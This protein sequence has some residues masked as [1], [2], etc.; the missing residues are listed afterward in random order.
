MNE[1]LDII[2][3]W[4]ALIALLISVGSAIYAFVTARSKANSERLDA[5]DKRLGTHADRLQKL[6]S[7]VSHL[8][9]KDQVNGLQVTIAEVKGLVGVLNE[10]VDGV[11]AIVTRID[12]FLLEMGR[13]K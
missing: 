11:G 7:E 12:K 8:P 9:N 6:E 4:L 1:A 10:R 5:I 2:Q 3:G 13:T